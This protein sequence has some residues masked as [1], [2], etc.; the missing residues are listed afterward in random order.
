M[1]QYRITR[2]ELGLSS[3]AEPDAVLDPNDPIH[4]MR[5]LA[6][7][8]GLRARIEQKIA[9]SGSP[10]EALSAHGS[11]LHKYEKDHRIEP[12]TPEWFRLWFSK[13]NLTGETPHD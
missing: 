5:S 9:E 13:P 12:G 7:L 10:G 4:E 2:E 1:K 11:E 8:P 6:G 3:S